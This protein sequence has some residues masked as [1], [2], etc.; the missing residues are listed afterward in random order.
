MLQLASGERKMFFPDDYIGHIIIFF[1]KKK[2][3]V[4]LFVHL[5]IPF[6]KCLFLQHD[7]IIGRYHLD[8]K[9]KHSLLKWNT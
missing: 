7:R 5:K 6:L 9:I 3:I 1:I 2:Y 4:V 8:E